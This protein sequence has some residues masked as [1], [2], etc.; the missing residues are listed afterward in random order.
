MCQ[1]KVVL[2]GVAAFMEASMWAWVH[3]IST[4]VGQTPR[5]HVV[6]TCNQWP[7]LCAFLSQG[8]QMTG[9]VSVVFALRVIKCVYVTRQ[10]RQPTLTNHILLH[11][12]Q[13]ELLS[14]LCSCSA[15]LTNNSPPKKVTLWRKSIKHL[16]MP[17]MELSG[18]SWVLILLEL[19]LHLPLILKMSTHGTVKHFG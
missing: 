15:P 9:V 17:P 1:G 7:G 2:C 16:V 8:H 3:F 6:L 12:E 14:D 10:H 11:S 18:L 19:G 5:G 13:N 4:W